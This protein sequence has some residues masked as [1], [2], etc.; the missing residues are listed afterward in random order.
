[1]GRRLARAAGWAPE[2]LDPEAFVARAYREVLGREPD[3][4]GAAAHLAALASGASRTDVLLALARSPEATTRLA[5]T[6]V[7]ERRLPDLRAERPERYRIDATGRTTFVATG[8]DDLVWLEERIHAA[9]YYDA[10][11]VWSTEVDEEKRSMA[12][13]VASLGGRRV[14]ELGCY[15]G[16]LLAAMAERGLDVHGV[17]LSL[18]AVLRA[19]AELR[20]R[21][22]VGD[23]L[24]A[25]PEGPFDVVVGLDIFEHVA[26]PRLRRLVAAVAGRLTPGGHVVAN[27]PAFGADD[28]FGEVFPRY[29]PSWEADAAAGRAFAELDCDALGYPR[30]GHLVWADTTWWE[31]TFTA[32][33]LVRDR[34]AE[35]A[36]QAR[37]GAWWAAHAPARRS[38]YL[39][40]RPTR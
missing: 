15:T 19:P 23:V 10:G 1:V 35:R 24:D 20:D 12:D 8:D 39:F 25:L 18:D 29:L 31:A 34:D 21:I 7:P 30:N 4:E 22:V 26:P 11:G 33:G 40:T 5:R 2:D 37:H 36:V 3:A 9:G 16:A 14:L 17:E 6:L 13:V 28:V 32:A 27:I 38:L